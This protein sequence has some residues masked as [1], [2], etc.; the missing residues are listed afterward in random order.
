MG[1]APARLAYTTPP[2]DVAGHLRVV[3]KPRGIRTGAA[4]GTETDFLHNLFSPRLQD[5][6]SA[7]WLLGK[8]F[9]LSRT[10]VYTSPLNGM[11]K[12]TFGPGSVPRP[13]QRG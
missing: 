6:A 7:G 1:D 10:L 3:E 5:Y 4:I 9:Y 13:N 12:P 11:R 2:L 8:T